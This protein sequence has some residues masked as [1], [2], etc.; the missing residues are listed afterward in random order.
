MSVDM[1][2][3][4]RIRGVF[5]GFTPEEVKSTEQWTF[6]RETQQTLAGEHCISFEGFIFEHRCFLT[7]IFCWGPD[8]SEYVLRRILYNFDRLEETKATSLFGN[9]TEALTDK[10]GNPTKNAEHLLEGTVGDILRWITHDSIDC[11]EGKTVIDLTSELDRGPGSNLREVEV[12]MWE[13]GNGSETLPHFKNLY[14]DPIKK[15]K[16]LKQQA[17]MD[18]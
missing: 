18:L 2:E 15:R 10:Y 3:E 1:N 13:N 14:I 11:I 12:L 16:R 5:W 9:L 6:K 17:T 8:S 4:P 7:Y